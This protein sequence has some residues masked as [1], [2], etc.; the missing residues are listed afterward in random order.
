[1][2]KLTYI[3]VLMIVVLS[4]CDKP[5]APDCFQSSGDDAQEIREFP[6]AITS[7]DHND[8]VDVVLIPSTENRVTV[9]APENLMPEITT[10]FNDGVLTIDNKNTCN[11]V[12]SYDRDII[13]EIEVTDAL[14]SYRYQGQGDITCKDTLSLDE[15]MFET[16]DGSGDIEMLIRANDVSCFNHTGV[17][18]YTWEG[19]AEGVEWFHQG[20]GAFDADRFYSKI[21]LT[22]N[23]SINRLRVHASEY[24]FAVIEN[25]G[26]TYYRGQPETIDTELNGAGELINL[27]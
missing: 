26:S 25:S 9:K 3:L 13:V 19:T 17:A 10:S 15:F 23:S 21:A 4:A 11:V 5:N 2:K 18:N 27:D 7:I 16:Y 6:G 20:Y 14:R 22:N 8:L 24:L 1:M 12:R